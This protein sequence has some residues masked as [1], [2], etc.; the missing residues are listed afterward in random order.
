MPRV[1]RPT[2][3]EKTAAMLARGE[4]VVVHPAEAARCT[5]AY[6]TDPEV[7][8]ACIIVS[9]N[10]NTIDVLATETRLAHGIAVA[11]GERAAFD[12]FRRVWQVS[13]DNERAAVLKWA[14]R[15]AA[16]RHCGSFR[17]T[18]PT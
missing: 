2:F 8:L 6:Q 3:A 14:K 12:A 16:P 13:T 5:A 4:P 9:G 17:W 7:L 10:L 15:S 11:D 18:T 1:R